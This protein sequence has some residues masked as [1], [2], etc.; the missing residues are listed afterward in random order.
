ML[1][2]MVV[3]LLDVICLGICVSV[4]LG[5]A[6]VNASMSSLCVSLAVAL[7]LYSA[8][9]MW[10][11]LL[12]TMNLTSVGIGLLLLTVIRGVCERSVHHF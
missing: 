4:G 10:K 2:P 11:M 1:M 3:G 9:V 6:V 8:T 7:A 5:D 12:A